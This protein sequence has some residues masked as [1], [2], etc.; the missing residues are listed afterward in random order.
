MLRT[1]LAALALPLLCGAQLMPGLGNTHHQVTTKNPE[2]QKYFDQGLGLIYGFNHEEAVRSFMKAAQLD[3]NCAMAWWGIA[4]ATGPNINDPSDPERMKQAIAAVGKAKAAAAKG[5]TPEERALIDAIGRRYS[6]DPKADLRKFAIDYKNAMGGIAKRYPNDLDAA[7]LFAES[8]MDLRPWQLWTPDGKPAEGTLEIQA[9]LE[10]VLKR[11]P[12]HLGAN[13]YYIHAME[14]SGHPEKAL[15]SAQRIQALAPAAGHVV[16]MPA[17]TYIRTG[18]YHGAS[19]ANEKAIAADQE[20]IRKY[21]VDDLY[22]MMYYPHNLQ[23][24]AVSASMEGRL[25]TS[26]RA[27][28]DLVAQVGPHVKMM[29][30]MLEGWLPTPVEILVRFRQWNDLL[31]LPAPEKT[32]HAETAMWNFGR[33]MAF[34]A[35]GRRTEAEAERR[36]MD[37]AIKLVPNDYTFGLNP[38]GAVLAIAEKTL[39][40]RIAE[41]KGDRRTAAGLLQQTVRLEDALAYDEPPAWYIPTRESLGRVLLMSG[42]AAG[43][44]K[45]FRAELVRHP[46]SGRAF[47]G[48]AEALRKQGRSADAAEMDAQF[49][50]AWKYAD[51]KLRI[52]DL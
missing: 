52:E 9:T 12:N 28:D 33:G 47:F 6:A 49:A 38:A 46:K 36:A 7:T 51:V 13:H 48:L 25:A 29:Q 37:A 23:F 42:D 45:V 30:N 35:T 18:D 34:G 43:A 16:H 14:A 39:D 2:A 15:A 1:L 41:V 31:R 20:Y 24:L 5:A 17:H 50:A 40:A 22:T 21:H 10:S 27:A 8:A 3:P 32:H 19:A 4:V 11:D 44:E 26:K